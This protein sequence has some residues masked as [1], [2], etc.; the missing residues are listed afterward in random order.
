AVEERGSEPRH[1]VDGERVGWGGLV[2]RPA[3]CPGEK[4]VSLAQL[5]PNARGRCA[6][7]RHAVPVGAARRAEVMGTKNPAGQSAFAAARLAVLVRM[8]HDRHCSNQG[9]GSAP[10]GPTLPPALSRSAEVI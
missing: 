3:G 4:V 8:W 5:L 7:C 10:A 2:Q 1:L 6:L 9:V